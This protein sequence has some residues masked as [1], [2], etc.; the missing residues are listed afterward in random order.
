[1]SIRKYVTSGEANSWPRQYARKHRR[2]P[3]AV[4]ALIDAM[5]EA[6]QEYAII[7]FCEERIRMAKGLRK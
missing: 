3:D 6:N 7:N 4:R 1:M 2:L 5:D